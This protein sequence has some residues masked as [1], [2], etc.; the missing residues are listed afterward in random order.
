MEK[1]TIRKMS[2]DDIGQVADIHIRELP[3]DFLPSLGWTFLTKVFY[4]AILA[5]SKAEGIVSTYK[6]KITGFSIVALDS[7]GLLRDVFFHQLL[8]FMLE[9]FKYIFR[10]RGNLRRVFQVYFSAAEA[11]HPV[12]VGEIY[13]IAV[14]REVQGQGIGG[15]LVASSS[16]LLQKRKMDGIFIKTL[17]ENTNWVNYFLEKGWELCKEQTING[18]EYVYLITLFK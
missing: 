15:K 10:L 14:S 7:S 9:V 17:K 16:R 5:S 11:P 3:D 18:R 6:G 12:N 8:R 13:F 1:I 2:A 4:P